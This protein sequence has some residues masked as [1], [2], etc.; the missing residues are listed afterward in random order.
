MFPRVRLRRFPYLIACIGAP[1]EPDCR[2]FSITML[3]LS[4]YIL[5]NLWQAAMYP[6]FSFL[7]L[8]I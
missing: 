6:I 7:S 1:L 2:D 5:L 3:L 4:I 8:R